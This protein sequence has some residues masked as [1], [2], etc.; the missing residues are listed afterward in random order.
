[1]LPQGSGR[2]ESWDSIAVGRSKSVSQDQTRKPPFSAAIGFL[3]AR[4]FF[5]PLQRPSLSSRWTAIRSFSPEDSEGRCPSSDHSLAALPPC[6]QD[7]ALFCERDPSEVL[8][9]PAPTQLPPYRQRFSG[10]RDRGPLPR[11][12]QPS[13]CFVEGVRS[14]FFPP[15]LLTELSSSVPSGSCRFFDRTMRF[16]VA[17]AFPLQVQIPFLDEHLSPH[18]GEGLCTTLLL[19]EKFAFPSVTHGNSPPL[20]PLG[21][22]PLGEGVF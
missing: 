4:N 9:A 1:M 20:R 12:H 6:S 21:C 5:F 22:A 14:H 10:F 3:S 8:T 15:L 19:D 11:D 17:R 13:R 16:R 18:H 2:H 7:I